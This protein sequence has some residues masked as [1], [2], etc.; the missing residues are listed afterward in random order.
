MHPVQILAAAI[1]AFSWLIRAGQIP[2][3]DL[4]FRLERW[5]AR[6]ITLLT[7]ARWI[8]ITMLLKNSNPVND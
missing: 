1:E 7:A 8:R 5:R 4:V 3:N 2:L 6:V